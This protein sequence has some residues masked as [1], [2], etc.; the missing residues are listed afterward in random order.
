MFAGVGGESFEEGSSGGEVLVDGREE[1]G[2][3]QALHEG[4]ML[5]FEGM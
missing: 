1:G 2:V 5:G 3:V 4:G